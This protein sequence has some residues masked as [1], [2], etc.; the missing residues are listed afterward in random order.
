VFWFYV[1]I[2]QKGGCD[3]DNINLTEACEILSIS[4]ATGRNWVKSGRL[5]PPFSKQAINKLLIDIQNNNIDKLKSRRNKT[6]IPGVFAPKGYVD[7]NSYKTV[8]NIISKAISGYERVILAEYSLKLLRSVGLIKSDSPILLEEYFA[9]NPL[10]DDLLGNNCFDDKIKPALIFDVEFIKGQDFLGLLYMSLQTL[11]NRKSNGVYYTPFSVVS[12][13]IENLSIS[14]SKTIIDPCC[15][16]GNFLIN[17]YLHKNIAI[18]N[19]FGTDIDEISIML[20][21]INMLLVSKTNNI[22]ILYK[23]FRCE[24]SLVSNNKYDVIIGNPPWGAKL[25]QPKKAKHIESFCLFLER[26]IDICSENGIISFILPEAILNV[27]THKH[28]REYIIENCKI[29]SIKY[30]GNVFSGVYTPAITL[31]LEKSSS[32]TTQGIIIR[33]EKTTFEIKTNRKFTKENI[34]FNITDSQYKIM[35]KI[36]NIKNVA[37]LKNN[38]D[39][40]LGIV[41]GDN[42]K[43]IHNNKTENSEIILKGSD[44]YKYSFKAPNNY[45]EFQPK[46]FQQVAPTEMYRAKEKLLYRFICDSLVFAYDNS[47][48]LSLNSANILIPKIDGLDIKYILAILNSR[49]AQFYFSLKYNSIKVLRSHI[50]AIPIPVV[51][52]AT[53]Q[54]I[55]DKV[56]KITPQVYEEIDK[57]IMGLYSLNR[58]EIEEIHFTTQKN[59]FVNPIFVV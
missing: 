37:Y 27:K 55:I 30:W 7:D 50:E 3:L 49:V 38:A 19:I 12:D 26:A 2:S 21:R 56:N 10:I 13:T 17:A 16:T 34:N 48:T 46:L 57:I 29:K 44:I 43:F 18:E 32:F 9:N 15:G 31:T 36:E 28:I 11:N 8:C 4:T 1:I 33:N 20:T 23:N 54:I 51:D 35:Q 59:A 41:T 5:V 53:Q 22:E 42:S 24:D 14:A 47:Q 40:A 25:N 6:H 39:F 52:K 45:I 58:L